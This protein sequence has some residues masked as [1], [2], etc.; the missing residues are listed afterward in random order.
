M[1]TL[2][3]GDLGLDQ[4]GHMLLKRALA[5][6]PVGGCVEVSG[7]APAL[8]VHLRGWCRAQGHEFALIDPHRAVITR[9]GARVGRWRGTEQAGTWAPRLIGLPETLRF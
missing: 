4:G 8:A 2:D 6:A 1:T 3:L 9:G 7:H 5:Q